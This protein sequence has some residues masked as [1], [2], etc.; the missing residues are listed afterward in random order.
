M[1]AVVVTAAERV[2]A[3]KLVADPEFVARYFPLQQL[4]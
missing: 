1:V 2:V 3:V 4:P